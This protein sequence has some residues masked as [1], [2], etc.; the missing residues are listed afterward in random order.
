MPK[1]ILIVD[2]DKKIRTLLSA[3]LKKQGFDVST[4]ESAENAKEILKLFKTDAMILDVMMPGQDGQSFLKELRD[5]KIM[6]PVLMLTAAG[7]VAN[8]LEGLSN[9]ADDYLAKPFEPKELVLR[10]Q[11]ILKRT[12][13]A[14][15]GKTTVAFGDC[16]YDMHQHLLSKNG[17][18]I[19]LTTAENTLL[20]K[21]IEKRGEPITRAELCQLT[22]LENER[23]LDVQIT[24]LRKKIESNIK[25]PV[26]IQTVRG[27]GYVLRVL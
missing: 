2:D 3:F 8:R 24:R 22:A 11:N 12:Q 17:E 15:E 10:L 7:D 21:L 13:D 27:Q 19:P 9:G 16:V 5:K 4:A 23:T 25:H 14:D 6:L 20:Q 18:N 26:C 1:H